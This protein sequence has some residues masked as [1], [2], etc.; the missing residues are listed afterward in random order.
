MDYEEKN[1]IYKSEWDTPPDATEEQMAAFHEKHKELSVLLDYPPFTIN[2][3]KR[4]DFQEGIISAETEMRRTNNY[5]RPFSTLEVRLDDDLEEAR[6]Y[7]KRY[8]NPYDAQQAAMK[9]NNIVQDDYNDD[10][11]F[12]T[13]SP[14]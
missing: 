2:R 10:I 11:Y 1:T 12:L 7:Q 8:G 6:L 13:P 14:K 3:K 9:L 4:K 5:E